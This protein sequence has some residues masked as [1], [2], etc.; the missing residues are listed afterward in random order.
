MYANEDTE[1]NNSL[2]ILQYA[3]RLIGGGKVLYLR[4]THVQAL[5]PTFTA[6]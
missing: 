3:R 1:S 4:A 6:I 2:S 5:S